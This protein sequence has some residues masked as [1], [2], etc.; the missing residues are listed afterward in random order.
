MVFFYAEGDCE[1]HK[2]EGTLWTGRVTEVLRTGY[3]SFMHDARVTKKSL[4]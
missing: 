1:G 2:S 3:G 4:P